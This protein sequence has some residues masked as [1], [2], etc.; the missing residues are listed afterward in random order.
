MAAKRADEVV[1]Q[2]VSLINVSADPAYESFPAGGIRLWFYVAVIVGITHGLDPGY[3]TG[4]GNAAYEH[5][6]RT[7]INIAFNLEGDK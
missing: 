2:L 6:V 7:E 1:R 4:L 5:P 3:N